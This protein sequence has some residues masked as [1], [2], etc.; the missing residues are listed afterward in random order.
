ME[1]TK[2]IFLGVR[3]PLELRKEIAE[4]LLEKIPKE[5]WRK[6]LPENLHITLKFLGNLD[7]KA[8]SELKEKCKALEEFEGFEAELKGVG[9][10]KG[11]VLW[12]G[13]GKGTEE[14]NLLS[15][16]LNKIIGLR[17]NRFHA[18]A[19][20]ARNKGAGKEETDKLIEEMRKEKICWKFKVN[21]FDIIESQLSKA[22]P[23]YFTLATISFQ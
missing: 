20:L 13:T 11:R 6:V 2:R 7:E 4:K 9:H 19:T 18:H 12:I 14:F 1:K 21:G 8:V 3:L 5:K 22:G 10:F 23:T 16:K 15:N 17:D